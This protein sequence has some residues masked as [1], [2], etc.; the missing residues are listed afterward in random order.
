ME[1]WGYISLQFVIEIVRW[2]FG[3]WTWYEAY[4]AINSPQCSP[5]SIEVHHTQT[6]THKQRHDRVWSSWLTRPSLDEQTH[7]VQATLGYFALFAN[8]SHVFNFFLCFVLCAQICFSL[9][10]SVSLYFSSF[11]TFLPFSRCVSFEKHN[12]KQVTKRTKPT[13]KLFAQLSSNSTRL[14]SAWLDLA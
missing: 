12:T 8:A 6:D 13:A 3:M 10:L 1:R 4:Q 9:S 2:A 5:Q 11:N 7:P 14:G